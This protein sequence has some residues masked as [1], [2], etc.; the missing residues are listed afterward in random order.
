MLACSVVSGAGAPEALAQL[1]AIR[2]ALPASVTMVVGGAGAVASR[3]AI[4]AEVTLLGD[5]AALRSFLRSWRQAH[6]R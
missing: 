1:A 5:L 2:A 4:P 6:L 3:E